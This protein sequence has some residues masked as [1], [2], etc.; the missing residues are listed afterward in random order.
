MKTFEQAKEMLK[1]VEKIVDHGM[2]AIHF[3]SDESGAVMDYNSWEREYLFS[4]NN[5]E[6]IET[7]FIAWQEGG[8]EK[9]GCG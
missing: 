6:E 3:F 8:E 5:F 4:F 9:G 1:K 2:I 7:S